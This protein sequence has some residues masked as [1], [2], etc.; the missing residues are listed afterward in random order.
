MKGE[1]LIEVCDNEDN[2]K[3]TVN[4]KNKIVD[5]YKKYPFVVQHLRDGTGR[6]YGLCFGI[7]NDSWSFPL[8]NPDGSF[9]FS[10]STETWGDE[11][12]CPNTSWKRHIEDSNYW[13]SDGRRVLE[14]SAN[15][16]YE[17]PITIKGL[18][19]FV[20]WRPASFVSWHEPTIP[21]YA[22]N[23]IFSALNMDPYIEVEENERVYIH[24][25][26]IMEW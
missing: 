22:W 5:Y 7:P 16:Y 12:G 3:Y 1:V 25:K 26:L 6:G 13:D 11:N 18:I 17:G 8:V 10:E 19:M 9:S 4:K 20:L 15:G 21:T 24:Y 14:F 2:L 23:H